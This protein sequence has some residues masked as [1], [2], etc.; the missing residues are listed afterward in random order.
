MPLFR[1]NEIKFFSTHWNL[2]HLTCTRDVI[3]PAYA[4][5][6]LSVR[7][8]P[9]DD[10]PSEMTADIPAGIQRTDTASSKRNHATKR[11]SEVLRFKISRLRWKSAQYDRASATEFPRTNSVKTSLS[12]VRNFK[13]RSGRHPK[14]GQITWRVRLISTGR[15]LK[16][17]WLPRYSGVRRNSHCRVK[18]PWIRPAK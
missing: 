13:I 2:E 12:R 5:R 15:K 14:I 17:S 18:F 7:S 9:A 3:P 10:F 6:P 8:A 16:Q 1:K 4:Q 11:P